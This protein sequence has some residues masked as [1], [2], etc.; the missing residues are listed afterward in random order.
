MSELLHGER[1]FPPPGVASLLRRGHPKTTT[2]LAFTLLEILVVITIMAVLAALV[3]PSARA[4]LD[5][6]EKMDSI[7]KMRAVHTALLMYAVDNQNVLPGTYNYSCPG[8]TKY[9][10][11][12][13]DVALIPYLEKFTDAMHVRRDR[14]I[15]H[16]GS[17]PR[18][19]ALNPVAVNLFGSLGPGAKAWGDVGVTQAADTGINLLTVRN[20]AKFCVFF[21][22]FHASNLVG[23]TAASVIGEPGND[24]D[25]S[26]DLRLTG[27]YFLLA[28]GHVEWSPPPYNFEAFRDEHFRAN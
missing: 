14:K 18:S 7:A 8:A 17:E 12:S 6:A 26:K 22:A 3:L 21:E 24:P 11:A 28:D 5:K 2:C 13:W 19:F 16:A 27:F 15:V 20:P 9:S 10:E 1:R 25:P 4:S 23:A